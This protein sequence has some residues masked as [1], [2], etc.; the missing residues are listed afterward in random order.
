MFW[1][2][3][4]NISN[5]FS[6]SNNNHKNGSYSGGSGGGGSNGG[7]G[8]SDGRKRIA[9][10]L[11]N[12]TD[13]EDDEDSDS[14]LQLSSS[15]HHQPFTISPDN[16]VQSS[17]SSR[18]NSG[19]TGN[20][21][22]TPTPDKSHTALSSIILKSQNK[23]IS[24]NNAG[25]SKGKTMVDPVKPDN[26]PNTNTT[27]TALKF[28]FEDFS[29]DSDYGDEDDDDEDDDEEDEDEEDDGADDVDGDGDGE[30]ED[31]DYENHDIRASPHVSSSTGDDESSSDFEVPLDRNEIR[32]VMK[33][34]II[35]DIRTDKT[36]TE[37]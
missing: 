12:M 27:L 3:V 22:S 31:E 32:G 20:I 10:N 25:V 29:D 26:K 19:I 23:S 4:K 18:S 36:A 11:L 24:I 7:G 30:A 33:S 8:G 35:R 13:D 15:P 6:F 28:T 16:L 17:T 9:Y 5:N 14:G 37:V 2:L 34:T 21:F 1:G